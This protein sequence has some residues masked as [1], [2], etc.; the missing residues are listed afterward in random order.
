MIIGFLVL[1]VGYA[2]Q[3]AVSVISSSCASGLCGNT[4]TVLQLIGTTIVILGIVII[5]IG[6]LKFIR[7]RFSYATKT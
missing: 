6:F 1:V 4:G 3:Y 2:I 7:R 5:A